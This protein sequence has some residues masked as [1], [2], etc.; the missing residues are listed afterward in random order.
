MSIPDPTTPWRQATVWCA[1]W[2]TAEQMGVHHLGPQLAAAEHR[3]LILSWWFIRK[4]ES[5]RIRY[6]PTP[7]QQE[8]AT[9]LIEQV[10]R[11][12]TATG[13]IR[14]WATAIYEP[15]THAFGGPDGMAI[16][17]ELFHADSR[18]I[19]D[20]L[21]HARVDHRRELGLILGA[22]LMRAADLDWYEQG[23]VWAQVAAH[24]TTDHPVPSETAARNVQQLITAAGHSA[25]SPLTAVPAWPDAFAHAG[26]RLA[27]LTAQGRLTRGLRSV[28]AHHLL[29]AWNRLGL[30]GEAQGTLAGT[31]AHVVFHRD[32]E[33]PGPQI[34]PIAADLPATLTAVTTD[35]SNLDPAQ[36]RAALVDYI[37]RRGTFRTS[38]VERAFLTVPRHLFLEGV[39]LATAYAPQIVVT[40]R[41]PDGTA[42]SSASHPNLVATQ[43]ED[44]D[45]HAGDRVLEIGAATGI[46]AALIAE[47]AG[48]SGR[49]VTIEIDEDL[50]AG[51]RAALAR[52]GYRN[53]EVICGDGAVGHPAGAPYDRIIV[54]AEAWDIPSPWWT[55][56]A[57]GGRIVVPLRLHGSGLTRSI[58]FDLTPSGRLV[59][60]HAR[61]CGF[62][63][64]RGS[65]AHDDRIVQLTSDVVLKLDARDPHDIDALTQALTHPAHEHWT[66]L[67][68]RDDGPVEHLD[69]WLATNA[70]R[71]GRL[72]V[73][74]AARDSGLINPALRWAGACLYDGGT[75]AYIA[76]RPH[77][78]N[79]DE[80]GVIAHGPDGVKL[81]ASLTD[82]LHQWDSSRPSQPVITAHP[83]STPD[84]ELAPGML[85]NRPTM[86]VTIGW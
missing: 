39:D 86:R 16:A 44:L 5:W 17:H 76:A 20:Y 38:Q 13:A 23:D 26:R 1:D 82:L 50:T 67:Q 45:V 66:G 24:R 6:L 9:A 47:V 78:E 85:I 37:R 72:S 40:K 71:F 51:A 80:L 75:I 77:S 34:S 74:K 56:L 84:D 10:M 46:N 36:L 29:F 52:A 55:Q 69:L 18:Y 3:G 54:T 43:L 60:R 2:S 48:K 4:A 12:L 28:L 22:T 8:A 49:V 32:L 15:E 7:D 35:T 68:V 30:P 11:E 73:T 53:V 19:L 63:P 21:R 83:A 59:S 57:P 64:M 14:R 62:V 33:P 70:S 41:A 81:A 58:A 42:I 27:E 25:D 61:V 79:V 65:T 31:A